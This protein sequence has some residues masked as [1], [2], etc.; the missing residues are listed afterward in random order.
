VKNAENAGHQPSESQPNGP[1]PSLLVLK[2]QQG[3]GIKDV[4]MIQEAFGPT[5]KALGA[6]LVVTD[7]GSDL[8]WQQDLSPLVSAITAQTEAIT[9]LAMSNEAL[10]AAMADEDDLLET[11]AG[12][13][14][15]GSKIL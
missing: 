12:T 1:R 4:K 8:H 3:L 13:Y 6:E 2:C 11:P 5:A 15:D 7:G 10:V 14:M 9:R